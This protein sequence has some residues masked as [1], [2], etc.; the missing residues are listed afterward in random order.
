MSDIYSQ[1]R[2]FVYPESDM[3]V[4]MYHNPDANSGDQ[5]VSVHVEMNELETA[6][7]GED[8]FD[9][10]SATCSTWL[11]D[12]GD[13]DYESVKKDFEEEPFA[14]GM[15]VETLM[16]IKNELMKGRN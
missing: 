12:V 5:F 7:S 4:W 9:Y 8:P 11:S 1:D 16:K 3:F 10:L 15:T 6:F 2:F 14:I 13:A